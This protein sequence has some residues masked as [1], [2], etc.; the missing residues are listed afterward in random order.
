MFKIPEYIKFKN[1]IIDLSYKIKL[2]NIIF[3]FIKTNFFP[4]R[5]LNAIA[6]VKQMIV[7]RTTSDSY[8]KE[9]Q[10]MIKASEKI[11]KN[12]TSMIILFHISYI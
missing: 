12:A 11:A 9:S 6:Q 5:L 7:T 2:Y 1:Q 3:Y 8:P 10:E 4:G